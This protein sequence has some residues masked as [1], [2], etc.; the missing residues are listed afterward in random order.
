MSL[1]FS[2]YSFQLLRQLAMSRFR[3]AT[4]NCKQKT[5]NCLFY[6]TSTD[7]AC[8]PSGVWRRMM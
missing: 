8:V 4:E 5:V 3:N 1:Q 2:V 6:F 7:V